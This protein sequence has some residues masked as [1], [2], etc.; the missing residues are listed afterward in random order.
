MGDGAPVWRSPECD[1]RRHTESF[2]GTCRP[3]GYGDDMD[4]SLLFA[5]VGATVGT[6]ALVGVGF[7]VVSY[8]RDHPKRR[9]EYTVHSTRLV[10][11]KRKIDDM[12]VTVRGIQVNDPHLVTLNVYSNS[13]A[14]IPSS[15]FDA[16][17]PLRIRVAP[18]G[19]LLLDESK[20]DGGIQIDGGHGENFEWAEFG[21]PPQLIRKRS[22][23]SIMFVSSGPPTVSVTAPLIDVD[24]REVSPLK[25]YQRI[26]A[27]RRIRTIELTIRYV[28]VG[29]VAAFFVWAVWTFTVSR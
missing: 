11:S 7:Q 17:D 3:G 22:E 15:A 14:D 28:I 2:E 19:A 27:V 25:E 18:G 4:W 8:F 24:V 23:G 6:L 16:G 29:G 13:R 5:I 9:I 12:V 10:A 20:N 21:V 26:P 1:R